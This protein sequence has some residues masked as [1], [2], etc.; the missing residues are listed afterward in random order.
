MDGGRGAHLLASADL[1]VED[2]VGA[3][4]VPDRP[5]PLGTLVVVPALCNAAVVAV[6]RV[7]VVS[8]AWGG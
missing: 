5:D 1:G 2:E 6:V 7:V 4:E 3:E 8:C